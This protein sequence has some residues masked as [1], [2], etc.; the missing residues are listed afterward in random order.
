MTKSA[1]CQTD[2]GKQADREV[3]AGPVE[4]D[5][6]E[7]PLGEPGGDHLERRAALTPRGRGSGSSSR[8]ICAIASQSASSASSSE[9]SG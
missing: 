8:Q 2:E 9:S 5:R 3:G 1:A 6:V 4:P 7:A